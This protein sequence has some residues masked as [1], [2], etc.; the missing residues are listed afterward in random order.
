MALYYQFYKNIIAQAL[1][2]NIQMLW[3]NN[4]KESHVSCLTKKN[5]SNQNI[6]LNSQVELMAHD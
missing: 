2:S 1:S 6:F 3:M 4:I 5:F